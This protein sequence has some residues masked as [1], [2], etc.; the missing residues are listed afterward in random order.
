M[1]FKLSLDSSSGKHH[2]RAAEVSQRIEYSYLHRLSGLKELLKPRVAADRPRSEASVYSKV[3]RI[4]EGSERHAVDF[5][6]CV[7]G[8]HGFASHTQ[9]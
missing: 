5:D 4:V 9:F 3:R 8:D 7:V 6:D 2:R 1:A